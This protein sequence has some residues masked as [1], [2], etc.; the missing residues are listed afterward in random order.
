MTPV[1]LRAKLLRGLGDE[2]RLRVLE[3][4]RDGP[5]SVSE[6]VTR[7]G[8]TQPN[9]SMHLSCLAECGLVTRERRGRFVEYAIAD[10]RVVRVLDDVEELLSQVGELIEDCPRYQ[11]PEHRTRRGGRRR[12]WR[13]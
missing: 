3:V 2:S 8:L 6:I 9:A 10:K 5:L 7:T 1:A 11:A 12:R 13:R 4:L